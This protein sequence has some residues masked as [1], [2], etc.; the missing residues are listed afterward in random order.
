MK[1][2]I[3]A[4]LCFIA[5]PAFAEC[6]HTIA[7]VGNVKCTDEFIQQRAIEEEKWFEEQAAK[8]QKEAEEAKQAELQKKAPEM[9][10]KA[11]EAVAAGDPLPDD[12]REYIEQTKDQPAE[13]PP[14]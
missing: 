13:D 11:I 3:A 5:S 2:F 14:P 1:Y 6:H 8:E 7:G 4:F 9:L 12:V 10:S